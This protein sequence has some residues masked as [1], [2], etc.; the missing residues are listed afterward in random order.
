M[1]A[2]LSGCPAPFCTKPGPVTLVR[3]LRQSLVMHLYFALLFSV[4]GLLLHR[5]GMGACVPRAGSEPAGRVGM[6]AVQPRG[7]AAAGGG[8]E[9]RDTCWAG[10]S[11]GRAGRIRWGRLQAWISKGVRLC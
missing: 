8:R 9:R 6:I 1:A 3:S 4:A 7:V 2:G 5:R 10:R 11:G